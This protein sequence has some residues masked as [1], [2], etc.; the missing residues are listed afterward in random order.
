M[1]ID[2]AALCR[3]L[4]M[5]K[6]VLAAFTTLLR[7][8]QQTLV[9]GELEPL[10]SYAEAKSKCLFE[11]TRL[12][13]QRHRLLRERGLQCDDAGM[14]R[15]LRE[16]VDHPDLPRAAWQQIIDLAKSA[17]HLNEINGTLI[18]TRLNSTQR[19]LSVIFSAARL[20]GAYTADGSTVCYRT[21]H[22]L[23]VA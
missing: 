10:G 18:G 6:E 3:M 15:L 11:L 16:H 9:R 17:K 21:A 1:H 12:G 7:D 22:Q 2:S 14:Q 23:A 20:P 19:A 8:E 4:Q 5:E 13:E